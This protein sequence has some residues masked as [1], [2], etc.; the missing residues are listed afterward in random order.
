M[1]SAKFRFSVVLMLV[2]VTE[3]YTAANTHVDVP[4]TGVHL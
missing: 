1:P 4:I 2:E 3:L